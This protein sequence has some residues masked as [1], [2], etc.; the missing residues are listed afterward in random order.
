MVDRWADS[1]ELLEPW[2]D[3]PRQAPIDLKAQVEGL[4]LAEI[5]AAEDSGRSVRARAGLLG[6][7]VGRRRSLRRAKRCQWRGTVVWNTLT[8]ADRVGGRYGQPSGTETRAE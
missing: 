6:I 4:R 2:S 1:S 3:D 5:I 8:Q 7:E